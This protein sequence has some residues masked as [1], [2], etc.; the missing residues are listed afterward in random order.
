MYQASKGNQI[1]DST[2]TIFQLKVERRKVSQAE[3]K[4]V[5]NFSSL[6]FIRSF[7]SFAACLSK[8]TK[9]TPRPK[10]KENFPSSL[11]VERAPL[12]S[13]NADFLNT[14]CVYNAFG[15]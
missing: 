6:A 2:T 9:T 12:R 11:N 4:K 3:K 13:V 14:L 1:V 15:K 7:G 10:L 5:E 8:L